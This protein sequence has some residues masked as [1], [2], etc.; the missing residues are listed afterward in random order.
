MNYCTFSSSLG[1]RSMQ[2]TNVAV[3]CKSCSPGVS[4]RAAVAVGHLV[5]HFSCKC[6]WFVGIIRASPRS[7]LGPRWL[8]KVLFR[9]LASSNICEFPPPATA[10]G[11]SHRQSFV[12]IHHVGLEVSDTYWEW[13]IADGPVGNGSDG[14]ALCCG[15]VVKQ[16]LHARWCCC[17][18]HCPAS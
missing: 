14:I 1:S 17:V 11:E 13:L 15:R 4:T 8:C 2:H 7:G 16:V 3:H 6:L 5:F 18:Q 10:I 9:L 12:D